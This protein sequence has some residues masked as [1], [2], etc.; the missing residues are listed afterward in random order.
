M[1]ALILFVALGRAV[2]GEFPTVPLDEAERR[3]LYEQAKVTPGARQ[4]GLGCAFYANVPLLTMVSGIN[5]ADGSVASREFVSRIY[6]LRKGDFGFT[7]AFDREMFFKLFHI[8]AKNVDVYYREAT[9]GELLADAEETVLRDLTAAL[10][11]GCF[12]SLRVLGEFGGPHNVLLL[13][14]RNGK[15]YHHEPRTGRIVESVPAVLASRILTVSKARS[16]LKKRYFSSWHLVALPAPDG[17]PAEFLTP[18]DFPKEL[19]IAL[20]PGRE[21]LIAASLVRAEDAEGVTASFPEIDFATKGGG[22]RSH[23]DRDL[24]VAG[25]YGVYSISK[26]ALNSRHSGKRGSLPVWLVDGAPLALIGYA[27]GD[28]IRL[29]FFDGKKRSTMS[30]A[31]A[32]GRFRKSGCY[33][34][35]MVLPQG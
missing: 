21:S 7:G 14:H 26:L 28:Q 3:A 11:R 10:D 18:A 16:K 35:Y 31:E 9:R 32:L 23:I 15:F 19:E 4:V 6:G 12:V 22:E 13:A 2:C 30:L 20:T 27:E 29:T 33:F 34:G 24:D 25:L 5:I 8:P 17:V 1:F